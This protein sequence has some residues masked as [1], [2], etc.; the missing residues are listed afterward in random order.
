LLYEGLESVFIFIEFYWLLANSL[1]EFRVHASYTTSKI[2]TTLFL[3]SVFFLSD[4]LSF[5]IGFTIC[6]NPGGAITNAV[7]YSNN[8]ERSLLR[9]VVNESGNL[10]FD[11]GNQGKKY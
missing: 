4:F 3:Y 6:S 7:E 11:Q 1:S 2:L 9:Q 8:W 5:G 10:K